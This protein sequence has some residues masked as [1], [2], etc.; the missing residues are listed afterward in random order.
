MYRMQAEVGVAV[1]KNTAHTSR[2]NMSINSPGG[3]R[4]DSHGTPFIVQSSLSLQCRYSCLTHCADNKLSKP[5][6]LYLL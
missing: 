4:V 3:I 5:I 1:A 2:R 6:I